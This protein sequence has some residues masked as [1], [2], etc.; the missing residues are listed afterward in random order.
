MTLVELME[1]LTNDDPP[2]EVS[3]GCMTEGTIREHIDTGGTLLNNEQA[4]VLLDEIDRLRK[5]CEH[6]RQAALD[7][8][9]ENDRLRKLVP[10]ETERGPGFVGQGSWSVYAEKVVAERDEA[11][12]D[13]NTLCEDIR[14]LKE[15][16]DDF[17]SAADERIQELR[18]DNSTLADDNWQLQEKVKRLGEQLAAKKEHTNVHFNSK[19]DFVGITGYGQFS[20]KQVDKDRWEIHLLEEKVT[21][22]NKKGHRVRGH[23]NHDGDW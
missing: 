15:E 10:P 16:Y 2:R 23:H 17:K 21:L 11:R 9:D 8:S 13:L 22:Y 7:I 3:N 1:N 5:D 18:E 20:L 6:H 19:D 4:R 12:D 14:V